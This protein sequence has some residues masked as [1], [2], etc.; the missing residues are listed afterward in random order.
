MKFTLLFC[1]IF[2]SVVSMAQD[3][4]VKNDG[5]TILSKVIKVGDKEIEY[6]KYNSS[7]ERLYSISTSDV[8][9]INYE[10]GD[11]DVF[12][13]K[14]RKSNESSSE[15]A[16]LVDKSPDAK[17]K[18]LLNIYNRTYKFTDKISR[19][20]KIAKKCLLIFGV[21]SNSIMSN[22]DVEMHIIRKIEDDPYGRSNTN[23]YIN[24]T[25]KT[26]K[27]IYIDK[28]NS[29]RIY[30]NGKYHCYYDNTEQTTVNLGGGNGASI[31]LGSIAGVLGIS[32][33]VGQLAS[34]VSVGGGSNH[35]TS[36]TYSQQRILAIPPHANV[37]LT[38]N[39]W[40]QT[41]KGN[42]LSSP[43]YDLIEKSEEFYL[44]WVKCSDLGLKRGMVKQGEDLC[45][46]EDNSPYT[47]QYIITYS[48]DANF[49][50]YSIL[51]TT[52]FLHQ[53]VG[54]QS[55]IHYSDKHERYIDGL[56]EYTIEGSRWF[57]K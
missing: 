5:S 1:F 20:N 41:K 11:K 21:K 49:S 50:N 29:F 38:E 44:E 2:T 10:D 7:S 43:E 24:L 54:C 23:Y 45:Y 9:A 46:S 35:S 57:D 47:K 22:E 53:L 4:I 36:K 56:N 25:N 26:D 27:T 16:K 52:V 30:N 31:G 17:N 14:E 28:G 37:N 8:M 48:S 12:G 13:G 34:G 19:S 42:L 33:A 18:E 39:R 6:K 32:G 15:S 3:V 40:V 55:S 51:K